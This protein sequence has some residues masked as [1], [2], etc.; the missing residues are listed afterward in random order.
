MQSIVD[1]DFNKILRS[2][3]SNN[4]LSLNPV[5]AGGFPLA[6]Y[7]TLDLHSKPHHRKRLLEWSRHISEPNPMLGSAIRAPLLLKAVDHFSDIDCWLLNK[8]L[9]GLGI[10][11]YLSD[12]IKIENRE[13]TNWSISFKEESP[14][15]FHRY[16]IIKKFFDSPS[17]IIS[18]FDID[19]CCIAWHDDVLYFSDGFTKSIYN[20]K[21]SANNLD[22]FDES[23]SLPKKV[24]HSL[25]LMK[26]IKRT[27]FKI[28]DTI[29]DYILNTFYSIKD[30]DLNNL[31][32]I[33]V[34][35]LDQSVVATS[36]GHDP[37][38]NYLFEL[39]KNKSFINMVR[40]L[41]S[42]FDS[43]ITISGRKE[44]PL[45]YFVGSVR[46]AK[47]VRRILEQSDVNHKSIKSAN[48][49]SYKGFN[50]TYLNTPF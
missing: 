21:I 38:H 48:K 27:D 18:T 37:N 31:R 44:N 36:A 8:D 6:L 22:C 9:K 32:D 41:D 12:K 3:V 10:D 34:N 43:F 20:G 15:C 35:L 50:A 29:H 11:D 17:D 4:V 33:N 47:V 40:T 5:I 24:F 49:K 23:D 25:R 46:Y 28:C 26:H 30:I 7:R 16:Q 45:L 2:I 1:K 13:D 42:M 39:T 14:V 19:L